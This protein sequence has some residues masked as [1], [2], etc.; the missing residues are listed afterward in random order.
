MAT[1]QELHAALDAADKAGNAADAKVFADAIRNAQALNPTKDMSIG[2]LLAAGA[3]K[4]V[5]DTGLGARQ[6]GGIAMDYLRPRA[7]GQPSR[8]DILNQEA[9]EMRRR[10]APL[11]DTA[12]GMLGNIGGNVAMAL[13]PGGAAVQVGKQLTKI[14]AA[15]RLAEALMA[16]GKAFMAPTSIPG[17]LGVGAVQGS[18]QP[19]TSGGERLGNV[20]L[21]AGAS[22]A[23]PTAI[24]AAQVGKAFIDP[25][26]QTGQQ[27]IVGRALNQ[28]AGSPE[29]AATARSNLNAAV[30]PFVGPVPANELARQMMGEIVPGSVPT[31]G[32]AAGVPS[33]AA[34]GRS[35]SAVDPASTNALSQRMA[36]QNAARVG[37]INRVAGADGA[38]DFLKANR[39]VTGNELYGKARQIGIDPAAMTPEAQQNIAAFQ[40]RVPD[41]ILNRAR[42]LA[43]ISGTNMDNETSVQGLHWIKMAIDDKI[44]SAARAG[45]TQM[46]NAYQGLQSTLLNGMDELSPAYGEA[47]RTFSAMSKPINEMEVAQAVGDKSINRL[48]G[49]VQP[50]AYARALSDNTVASTL[51]RPAATLE[52]TMQPRNLQA[53]QNVQEDLQRANFGLT[54]GKEMGGSDTAQKLA[55]SNLM[56]QSG[57]PNWVQSVGG[58]TGIGGLSQKIGQAVYRDANQEMSQKL[59]Q[60][61]LDPAQASALM[62]AGMVTPQMIQAVNAARRLGSGAGAMAPALANS[63]APQEL[64]LGQ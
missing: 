1:L 11:M 61:L 36:E 7:A 15:A 60:A 38:L 23:V 39:E 54:A 16:G 56:T 20:A 33:I 49:N 57:L 37:E 45:D 50:Q 6:L 53:L 24:R 4:A 46:K 52:N 62:E 64:Y 27:Q 32:Q 14:P 28:A 51:G 29:A 31:T 35:A 58:R 40:T 26:S 9:E 10:D 47:R 19:A 22:A 42:E 59:A 8:T 25:L 21:G 44:S 17:A 63:V 12:S 2:D 18:L 34:L 41:E 5:A 13:L 30:A 3:G 48:T 55:Y 43:K